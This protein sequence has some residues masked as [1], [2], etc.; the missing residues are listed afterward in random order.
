MKQLTLKTKGNKSIAPMI[1][2]AI[3]REIKLLEVGIERTQE[4][5]NYFEK[6]YGQTTE[7]FI[8]NIKKTKDSDN[9]ELF[10]WLGEWKTLGLLKEKVKLLKAT[11]VCP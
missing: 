11:K 4:R 3:E 6:T 5:L 7:H 10:E 1:T 9:L 8:K 2:A